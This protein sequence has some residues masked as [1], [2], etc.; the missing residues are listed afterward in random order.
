[1]ALYSSAEFARK[2]GISDAYLTMMKKRGKVVLNEQKMVDDTNPLNQIFLENQKELAVKRA[3]K[4][5]KSEES[6]DVLLEEQESKPEVVDLR[7]KPKNGNGKKK[8]VKNGSASAHLA[9][10]T[11]EK[12]SLDRKKREIEIEKM[13]RETHLLSLQQDKLAGKLIPTDMVKGLFAQHFKSVVMTFKQGI[14]QIVTEFSKKS[15]LNRNETAELKGQMIRIINKS[16]EEAI[17][18]SKKDLSNIVSEYS[19]IKRLK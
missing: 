11:L 17:H 8:E 9:Q 2:C 3:L 12:L 16:V 14:D 1:M 19:Q 13:Q 5:K 15:K 10:E 7:K 4:V 6:V 18:V